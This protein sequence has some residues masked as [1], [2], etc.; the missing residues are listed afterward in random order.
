MSRTSETDMAKSHRTFTCTVKLCQDAFAGKKVAKYKKLLE[1]LQDS[2]FK[3]DGDFALYKKYTLKQQSLTED[4]FNHVTAAD[5]ESTPRWNK[6]LV[7]LHDPHDQDF[8]CMT[9]RFHMTWVV[10]FTLPPN[11]MSAFST[12]KLS[13]D[14]ISKYFLHDPHDQIL[15]TN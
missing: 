10:D 9:A 5:G 3:L 11:S 13:H 4:A 2:F 14:R 15:L 8:P 6:R 12:S 7:F 1:D